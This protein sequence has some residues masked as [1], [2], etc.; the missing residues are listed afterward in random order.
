MD[1]LIARIW[2]RGRGIITW[3]FSY[4]GSNSSGSW[5]STPGWYCRV[6]GGRVYRLTIDHD[7]PEKPIWLGYRKGQ[8]WV[9][10]E[11][12]YEVLLVQHPDFAITSATFRG[13]PNRSQRR[14]KDTRTYLKGRAS[15]IIEA[16]AS[17]DR[18]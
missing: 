7:Y 2:R 11:R 13:F 17:G 12:L 18:V 6:R 8:K 1:K 4:V 16:A 5:F 15:S 10:A 3:E 14:R 9:N